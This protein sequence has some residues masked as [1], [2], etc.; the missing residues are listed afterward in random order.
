[1]GIIKKKEAREGASLMSG[2]PIDAPDQWA[3]SAQ[4]RFLVK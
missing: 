4:M 3:I 2:S 1:M